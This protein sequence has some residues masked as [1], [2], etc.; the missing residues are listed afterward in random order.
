[1][2]FSIF[3]MPLIVSLCV[4]MWLGAQGFKYFNVTDTAATPKKLSLTGIYTS[5]ATKARQVAPPAVRFEVNSALWSDASHKLRWV[6]LKPGTSITFR[7]VEDFYDYPESTVFIKQ[8]NIDT[9]PGDTTSRVVWETRLLIS[10]KVYDSD[11][12][13]VPKVLRWFSF[14]YKWQRD[15][16]DADLVSLDLG[17]NDTVR[18]YPD[19]KTKPSA[20]KKWHFPSRDQCVKCHINKTADGANGRAVL[21]FFTAQLNA[22]YHVGTMNQLDTLFKAGI[23]KVA[24]PADKP[25]TWDASPRWY[26]VT[27][28]TSPG[29]SVDKRARAYIAANCSGCHG[30]RGNKNHA[31]EFVTNIDF[32]FHKG[33]PAMEV[34][35]IAVRRTYLDTVEPVAVTPAVFVPGYPQ[36]SMAL[37]RQLQRSHDPG[38]FEN[39]SEQMPP[40]AT[41]EVNTQAI[42]LLTRWIKEMPPI[43]S[44]KPGQG[45]FGKPSPIVRGRQILIPASLSPGNTQVTLVSLRG[46]AFQVSRVGEGVYLVPAS[47]PSGIYVLKVGTLRFLRQLF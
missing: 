44:V 36:K 9:V 12:T 13:T 32:D 5:I 35:S 21:G 38:D 45:A 40:L 43:V 39:N 17:N 29:S 8:F 28:S 19:G 24:K 4:P 18:V 2:T 33:Q 26:G 31:A 3:R 34:R 22:R 30:F 37:F 11:D 25:A 20:M 15:Q 16:K 7:E 42:A 41:F 46:R 47:L 27:D 6:L 23:L 1:M 10:K 14:S